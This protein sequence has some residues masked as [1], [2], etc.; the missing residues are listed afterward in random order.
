M[1]FCIVKGHLL[2]IKRA[3]FAMQKGV[4]YNAKGRVLFCGYESFLQKGVA[5]GGARAFL[6]VCFWLVM[7]NSLA[8]VE[9]FK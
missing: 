4:F 9:A 1:P 5:R 3:C 2:H 7:D 8:T 6:W